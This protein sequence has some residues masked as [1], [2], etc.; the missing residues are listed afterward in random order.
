MAM[1]WHRKPDVT[2]LAVLLT[3]GLLCM[4]HAVPARADIMS[5][6]SSNLASVGDLLLPN[7]DHVTIGTGPQYAPDYMG[8]ND[9]HIVPDLLFEVSFAGR[10][11]ASNQGLEINLLGFDKVKLGPVLTLSGRRSESANPALAGLGDVKRSPEVGAFV[12]TTWE[13]MVTLR[14]R[15]RQ[16]I[17]RGHEGMLIDLWANSVVYRTT[18]KRLSIYTGMGITWTNGRYERAF[19]GINPEQALNSGLPEYRP[20]SSLRDVALLAG[21][22]RD[23]GHD[24]SINL[25]GA[26]RRYL[27]DAA[28]SPIVADYG[29]PNNF[30]LSL[31]LARTFR[32]N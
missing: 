26:Y 7:I 2:T 19:F 31:T 28:D 27:G 15:M 12:R 21:A 18:S 29:S 32:L 5:T 4:A 22:R 16:G 3:A 11:F 20:G 8:S 23:I 10:V 9:Y 24:W 25:L 13:N 1:T 17:A 30:T 6:L 14:L